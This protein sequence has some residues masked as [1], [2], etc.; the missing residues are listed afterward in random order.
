MCFSSFATAEVISSNFCKTMAK[1][2]FILWLLLGDILVKKLTLNNGCH[3]MLSNWLIT[4]QVAARF[5]IFR[6]LQDVMII[7]VIQ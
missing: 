1:R 3:M 4:F 5:F 6:G 7:D 2:Y